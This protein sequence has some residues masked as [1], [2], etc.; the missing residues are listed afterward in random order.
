M[1]TVL[2]LRMEVQCKLP[3]I[4]LNDMEGRVRLP[5][6]SRTRLYPVTS[7]N[8]VLRVRAACL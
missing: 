7:D 5:E 4:P 1:L 8:V 3:S 6:I 2:Q